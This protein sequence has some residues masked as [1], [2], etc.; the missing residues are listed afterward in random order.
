M[1]AVERYGLR[2]TLLAIAL[3]LVGIPFGFL[4]QQVLAE[5]PLTRLDLAGARWLHLLVVEHPVAVVALELVSF[6][7]KPIFLTVVIGALSLW[8]LRHGH[9]K[10]VAFLV[11][12]S[13]GGGVV[14]SIVKVAVGRSRPEFDEPVA[15]AFG[16]SFPS[17][18]S[19]SSLICY[20][21]VLLVLLPV[22]PVPLRRPAIVGTGLLV[23]AIGTS[24]LALGVHFVSDVAG[25]YVLGAAW[26]AAS[27]AAF[28]IWR[29]ERGRRRT[30]PLTEG[31]DPE[32]A[33]GT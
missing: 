10:L 19:M 21:A 22:L 15:T 27:V 26:L 7:G 29:E 8:L 4:L 20:G 31:M 33:T 9:R 1:P 28:E 5:G 3:A 6:T 12:T 2:V 30:H 14:D 23:L 17:G 16:N 32:V 11:V 25:G 13:V 18:H 24:R